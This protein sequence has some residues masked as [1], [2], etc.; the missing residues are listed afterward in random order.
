[1]PLQDIGIEEVAAIANLRKAHKH[2]FSYY[3]DF[4]FRDCP[5]GD[6]ATLLADDHWFADLSQ[7]LREHR[8]VPER[9]AFDELTKANYQLRPISIPH[10][11]D[12][13][14][15]QAVLNLIGPDLD[16]AISPRSFA[17]RVRV[18]DPRFI[19]RRYGDFRIFR[20]AIRRNVT[21]ERPVVVVSDIVGFYDYISLAVLIS[22]LRSFGVREDVADLID[23][24][25]RAWQWRPGY[26][27]SKPTGLAQGGNPIAGFYANLYL[28]P[29]DVLLSGQEELLHHRWNDDFA[30]HLRD[31]NAAKVL[32]GHIGTTLRSLGLSASS[33]KTAILKGE[34]IEKEFAFTLMDTLNPHV[35]RER[36]RSTTDDF[37]EERA[38]LFSR[39]FV[40]NKAGSVRR[41]ALTMLRWGN[42]SSHLV[43]LAE[44]LSDDP[45]LTD[46]L[47]MVFEASDEP[48][49]VVDTL[50]D[51]IGSARN[52]WPD[53]EA[54]IWRSIRAMQ[55][56]ERRREH[57][58]TLAK[59][60][61]SDP[62][63]TEH[64]R[65]EA[66]LS[67]VWLTS[68]N[69]DLR[70]AASL[71][72]LNRARTV[73]LA[74]ARVLASGFARTT[75]MN[76]AIEW[77]MRHTNKSVSEFGVFL[78]RYTS[79]LPVTR[80]LLQTV[81]PVRGPFRPGGRVDRMTVE[82][83]LLLGI[84]ARSAHDEIKDGARETIESLRARIADPRS[85]S[86]LAQLHAAT[87]P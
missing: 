34:E 7:R 57:V 72:A 31:E 30:V 66:T 82:D 16:S 50:V 74:K 24:Q 33:G 42:D 41:R 76:E 77:A 44:A 36:G 19:T 85:V 26:K 15:G 28:Q 10:I 49:L 75:T 6:R 46:Q 12:L 64:A 67:M 4:T 2:V 29:L 17:Y 35:E 60:R 22:L 13:I 27:V 51:Y 43:Q 83:M 53:Q 87:A 61:S 32:V 54:R 11:E 48:A 78:D 70:H 52:V 84:A 8:F 18:N 63:L 68:A 5:I 25:L 14:V 21:A 3:G 9:A 58:A 80:A 55:V 73:R 23:A 40:E 62:A 65:A 69:A 81:S 38:A 37:S 56:P 39:C 45:G 86:L 59:R 79:E 20:E 1:M 71:P 47:L